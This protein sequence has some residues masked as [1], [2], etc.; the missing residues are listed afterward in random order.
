MSSCKYWLGVRLVACLTLVALACCVGCGGGSSLAPVSGKVT[1]KGGQPVTAGYVTYKPDKAKGNNF[2]GEPIGEI[3]SDG[4]YTLQTKGKPG[5][6]LGA[7]KVIVSGGETPPDNTK[8]P[9]K[10]TVNATYSHPD[11]TTLTR[12]VV[13]KAAPGAYDLEVTP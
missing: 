1:Y 11:T 5:A 2:G 9:T 4:S 12:D 7:Y 3:K 6:P 10:Q 13:A 8:L